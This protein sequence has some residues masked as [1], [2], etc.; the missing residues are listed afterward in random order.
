MQIILKKSCNLR[1]MRLDIN[2]NNVVAFTAKL[3]R[4]KKSD[5]PVAIRSALNDTAFDVKTKTMPK[6]AEKFVNRSP[7]F[8]KANSKYEKAEGFNIRA[9]KSTVGFLS[10][11]LKGGNNFAVKDLEQQEKGGT[12]G[13]KSFIPMKQ[14]RMGQSTTKAV[15]PNNRTTAIKNIVDARKMSGVSEKQKFRKAA[16]RAGVGGHV[17]GN[18]TPAILW[19]V[20]ALGQ[21]LKMTPLYTY[22]ENREVTVKKTGFMRSASET[23]ANK[24]EAFFI[25]QAKRRIFK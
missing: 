22:K 20:N 5:L 4:M 11:N 19:R 6:S 3:E 13:G 8:F 21:P 12:I 2:T 18:K 7:N 23:S 17:L 16:I 9:M 10:D 1:A 15:R 24:M 25:A 14:A